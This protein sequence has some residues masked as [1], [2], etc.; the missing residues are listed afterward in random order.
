MS[1]KPVTVVIGHRDAR[2]Y[3]QNMGNEDVSP[4]HIVWTPQ[5]AREAAALILAAADDAE[6][7]AGCLVCGC[8]PCI[9][10]EVDA[11]KTA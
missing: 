9:C 7:G 11:Q 6:R 5:Q 4:S 3:V 2:V 10:N 1:S 8:A